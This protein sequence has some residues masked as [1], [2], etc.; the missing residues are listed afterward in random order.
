MYDGKVNVADARAAVGIVNVPVRKS[1]LLAASSV[2]SI[3]APC[4]V[5]GCTNDL[6]RENRLINQIPTEKE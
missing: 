3:D 1:G 6:I 2:L 5:A 4:L